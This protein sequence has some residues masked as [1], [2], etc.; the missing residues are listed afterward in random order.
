MKIHYSIFLGVRNQIREKEHLINLSI[1]NQ[2]LMRP[3]ESVGFERELQYRKGFGGEGSRG[4]SRWR[5]HPP[6]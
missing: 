1:Y 4:H 2:I 5:R 6:I 3:P